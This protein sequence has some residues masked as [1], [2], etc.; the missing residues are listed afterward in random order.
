M[1]LTWNG[2]TPSASGPGLRHG[3]V[4]ELLES[5]TAPAPATE[6][7][8]F[9]PGAVWATLRPVDP[10]VDPPVDRTVAG[11]GPAAEPFLV[12]QWQVVQLLNNTEVLLAW[13]NLVGDRWKGS[14]NPSSSSS[15]SAAAASARACGR[16]W[17]SASSRPTLGADFPYHI[18]LITGASG[19][20]VQARTMR[21]RCVP[22][23]PAVLR[24]RHGE[25]RRRSTAPRSRT[26]STR[27]ATDQLDAVAGRMLFADM[28]ATFGPFQRREDRG[29][30][31][32]QTW[33]RWTGGPDSP[34]GRPLQSYAADERLG[35]RPSLVLH[36][37]DGRGRPAAADQQ[38]RPGLRH[39]ERRRPAH[40]AVVAE[41]RAAHDPGGRLRPSIHEED[42]VFSLSAVE[43]FRLF[44]EAHDFQVTTAIRMSA[45]FP[46]CRPP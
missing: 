39:A 27:M 42:D 6:L 31:L 2:R 26:S 17:C 40:R 28:P 16:R 3:A 1:I 5:G 33:I 9:P 29:R 12:G 8:A 20:M 41:D 21:R 24:G 46:G 35:W 7:A 36:A 25:L 11:R 13:K 22:P 23:P 10:P 37:D 38:P 43:F 32:E 4:F 44:P 30:T 15:R 14:A 34:L 18:R 19:G 45:R